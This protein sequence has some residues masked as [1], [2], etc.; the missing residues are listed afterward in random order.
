MMKEKKYLA[1]GIPNL[2]LNS[3]VVDVHRAN[4]EV[5]TNGTY[6]TLRVSV[7]S[8]AQKQA[9]LSDTTVANQKKFEKV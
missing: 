3:F 2:K 8:K 4:L 5:N 9:G 6:I 7:I 1:R